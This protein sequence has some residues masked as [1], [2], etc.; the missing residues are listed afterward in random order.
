MAADSSETFASMNQTTHHHIL[1]DYNLNEGT[2][3]YSRGKL[4][5]IT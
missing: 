1:E 4:T 3:S 2:G 5:S